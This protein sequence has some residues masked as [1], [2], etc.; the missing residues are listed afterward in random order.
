M[1]TT[2]QELVET[3]IHSIGRGKSSKGVFMDLSEALDIV[4]HIT[5]VEIPHILG[6]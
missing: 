2:G 6:V 4:L 1:V 5:L 3:I